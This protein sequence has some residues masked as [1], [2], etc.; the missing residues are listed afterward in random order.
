MNDNYVDLKVIGSKPEGPGWGS[1]APVAQPLPGS[2]APG[3]RAL[4]YAL[5][6]PG[7]LLVSVQLGVGQEHGVLPAAAA[8]KLKIQGLV[9][10]VLCCR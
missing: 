5:Y 8:A 9:P 6:D 3:A 7:H 2:A 10:F 4:T 1:S